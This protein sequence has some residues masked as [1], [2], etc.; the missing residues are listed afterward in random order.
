MG[1][2]IYR[3]LHP[4]SHQ[5]F[6]SCLESLASKTPLDIINNRNFSHEAKFRINTAGLHIKK[7]CSDQIF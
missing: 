5:F 3:F 4:S 2:S 6:G 1:K 7:S